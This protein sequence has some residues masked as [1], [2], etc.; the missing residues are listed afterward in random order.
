MK[1]Y[2]VAGRCALLIVFAALSVP[3]ITPAAAQPGEDVDYVV[4]APQPAAV[5]GKIEIIEFFFYGCEACS[6]LEPRLQSWLRSLPADVAFRRVPALR[7]TAWVPLTRL[8]FVL[9]QLGEVER[10]H[11]R[12]YQAVHD[13]GLNLG[14]I[15][16]LFPWAQRAGLDRGRLEELL[17]S[18][19][20][21]AQVQRARDTTIAFGITAT[22]SFIVD[23]R[24]LTSA[25]MTGSVEALLPVVDGLVKKVRA[26]RGQ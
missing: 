7:R 24:Y 10:L 22:P 25:G 13:D 6:R 14:N 1:R 5:P 17:D 15:S 26:S 18:D 3:A 9:E 21:G 2:N 4:V 16:E 8:Y 19:L 12:V 11:A 23:G 20:I